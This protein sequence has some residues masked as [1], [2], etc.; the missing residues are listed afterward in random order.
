M[1]NRFEEQPIAGDLDHHEVMLG[2]A[3]LV[4]VARVVTV[5]GPSPAA[6]HEI[7]DAALWVDSLVQVVMPAEH[8][9]HLVPHERLLERWANDVARLRAV[10]ARGVERVVKEADSPLV[11]RV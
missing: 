3:D 4:E 11:A 6:R 2:D 10:I 8:D 9:V 5:Q 1:R 7:T